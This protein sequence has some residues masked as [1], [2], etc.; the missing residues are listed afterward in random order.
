[1]ILPFQWLRPHFMKNALLAVL[2]AA[3]LFGALGTLVVSNQMAFFSDAIGH[4]ALTGIAIGV[5]FG[6]G[7]PLIAMVAFS[8]I[9]GIA[10]IFVKS[11]GTASTDTIIG[12]F[13]SIAVALGIVLLS[14][15]GNFARYSR[16][17]VGDILSITPK[18]LGLL[19]AALAAL[20]VVWTG[21]YNKMLI[22]SVNRTFARS[23]GFR[24]FAIEQLF[25][26]ITAVIVTIS[27]SWTGLLVINSLL[28]LPAASGR[29]VTRSC[30]GYL[31]VS[32]LISLVSS[33]SGLVSSYYLGTASG[34]AIVLIS[35]CFFLL[36]LFKNALSAR[37]RTV[38]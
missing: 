22:T 32:V 3:P 11:R 2:L 35:G 4:S 14:T 8:V 10:I 5:I 18:E 1:M 19:L 29:M 13:S 30:R 16:Y 20:A 38:L 7:E 33:V 15:G 34:A 23:R 36:A 24:V 17:L 21:F 26:L 9:L 31:L 37:G 6:I 12:V 25:G 27:I 28:V